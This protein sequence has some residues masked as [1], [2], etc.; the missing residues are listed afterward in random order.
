MAE[1]DKLNPMQ[2]VEALRS[3]IGQ[4]TRSVQRLEQQSEADEAQR[5]RMLA[6]MDEIMTTMG[7]LADRLEEVWNYRRRG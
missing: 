3:D 1:W 5:L 4:L 6:R 7:R 2:R